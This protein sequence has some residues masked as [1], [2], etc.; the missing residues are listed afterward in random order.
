MKFGEYR[1]IIDRIDQEDICEL[2]ILGGEPLLF[3]KYVKYVLNNVHEKFVTIATNGTLMTEE[4][5]KWIVDSASHASIG[6]GIDGHNEYVHNAVRGGFNKIC[7]ALKLL[8]EYSI[9]ILATTC[10]TRYNCDKI[11]DILNFLVRHNVS[12]V[13]IIPVETSHLPKHI[14]DELDIRDSYSEII[15]ELIRTVNAYQDRINIDLSFSLHVLE[16]RKEVDGIIT[17]GP[18][19]AGIIRAYINPRSELALCPATPYAHAVR[20]TNTIEQAFKSLKKKL[21]KSGRVVSL[22]NDKLSIQKCCELFE[23]GQRPKLCR[24]IAIP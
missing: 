8:N 24:E 15:P 10:V 21:E 4:I 14:A 20:I 5:C 3:P 18:C 1:R 11:E 19:A 23:Y 2:H 6:I 13:Q 17:Y 16:P 9:P 22:K 12:G 7:D